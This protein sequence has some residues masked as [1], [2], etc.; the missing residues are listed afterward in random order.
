MFIWIGTHV[1]WQQSARPFG[2]TSGHKRPHIPD[3]IHVAPVFNQQ[4]Q[5]F[6]ATCFEHGRLAILIPGIRIGPGF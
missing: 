3:R 5:R 4:T 1:L 6:T 2:Q